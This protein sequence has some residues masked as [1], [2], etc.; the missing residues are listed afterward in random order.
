MKEKLIAI[1]KF[2][3][4]IILLFIAIWIFRV[5]WEVA[6]IFAIGRIIYVHKLNGVLSKLGAYFMHMAIVVDKLGNVVFGQLLNALWLRENTLQR[7]FGHS[8]D[9][10]SHVMASQSMLNNLNKFGRIVYNIVNFLDPGH[11]KKLL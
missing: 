8:D 5:F 1:R 6:I 2:I 7:K 3:I 9:T 10:I 11:F 4:G